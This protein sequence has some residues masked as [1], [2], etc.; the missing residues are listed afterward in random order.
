MPQAREREIK[1]PELTYHEYPKEPVLLEDLSLRFMKEARFVPLSVD[2]DVLRIAMADPNDIYT[3][4]ALR[5]A[6]G[7]KVEVFKGNE[8]D[9][10]SAI[11]RLY[12]VGSQSLEM[13]IEEAGR[14][15]YD[16]SAEVE[17]DVDHLRDLAS[18]API[19]R[20]VNRLIIN[21]VDLRASDIHFEPFE[22]E[23]KV[24]YRIDGVLHEVESPPKRLSAAITS[25]IKIMAKLDIAERRLPQDGRIKMRVADKEI[26]F[27]VSTIP[28]AFG[29]SVV[30]RI[31][32]RGTLILDLEKLGLSEEML[33]QY[34]RL[35]SQPYGM[36][37][38]C[39][40]TGSGKTTTLYTTLTRLN[41]PEKKIITLE[42]PI[43]YQLKGVNQ[44]QVNPKTGLTFATGLRSIVRQDPDI[45]LVGEI[46]DLETAEIAVQSALTGHL[47]FSTLHTNDSVGAIARLLDMGVENFLLN[48]TLLGVLSQRLVRVICPHCKRAVQPDK[49]QLASMQLSPDECKDIVF[50]EGKGCEMCRGTGYSGRIG[51]F[52]YLPVDDEIRD[53]IGKKSASERIRQAAKKKGLTT[54]RDNGWEKVKQGITTIPEVL[55]VTLEG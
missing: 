47:L 38:V 53:L 5:L 22:D 4:D 35:I 12:G 15:I 42:D 40:P 46:R 39:G 11:E 52:E 48:S 10:L 8:D 13:I 51:I 25:R 45:I 33:A 27:R 24:R 7:M 28:T 54:L 36:I 20:L 21:A 6:Y 17:E 16:L 19:I 41:S 23:S 9:I 26:D 43:E 1:I 2:D 32:D 3:I 49:R 37:L 30:M 34:L 50:Y 18:E 31:L 29:E 14:D 44:I 55:R